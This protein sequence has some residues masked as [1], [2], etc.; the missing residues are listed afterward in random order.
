MHLQANSC[1]DPN[2]PNDPIPYGLDSDTGN[3]AYTQRD[4]VTLAPQYRF[5]NRVYYVNDDDQL[6]RAELVGDH[7]VQ[8]VLADGIESMSFEYGMDR[9][10]DLAGNAVVVDGQ[11]DADIN[12]YTPEPTSDLTN[13]PPTAN[14][15]PDSAWSDVVMVRISLVVRN[16]EPSNGYVDTKV[17]KV[18]GED[19]DVPAEF[20]RHRRQVYTRTVSLRNIAGR[21][22]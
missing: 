16:I 2:D 14:A 8:T 12:G 20:Q 1:F 21:R 6:M 11:L 17:Y 10:V 18:A 5:L 13:D 7:Y 3:L 15:F 9:S 22:E 19:Y 4:C